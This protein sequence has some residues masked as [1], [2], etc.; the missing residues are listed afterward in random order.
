VLGQTEHFRAIAE[1]R[2]I[3]L[4]QVELA[5]VQLGEMGNELDR[6]FALGG[7]ENDDA[8]EEIR[9]G[10]PGRRG[11]KSAVPS[12]SAFRSASSVSRRTSR[13]MTSTLRSKPILAART[14]RRGPFMSDD[15]CEATIFRE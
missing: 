8:A 4:P 1:E 11:V 3:A 2:A 13:V 15:R 12:P 6:G 5:R 7:R 9:V 14:D 10:Q